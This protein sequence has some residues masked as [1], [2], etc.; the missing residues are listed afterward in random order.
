[1]RCVQWYSCKH[2]ITSKYEYLPLSPLPMGM[3]WELAMNGLLQRYA[4]YKGIAFQQHRHRL[5]L[6][7]QDR[8]G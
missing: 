1:M 3:K 5:F 8:A 4:K 7:R 6:A 2:P